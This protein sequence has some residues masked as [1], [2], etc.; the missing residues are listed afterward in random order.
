MSHLLPEQRTDKNGVTS[1]KWVRPVTSHPLTHS[2][3]P[4]PA[5]AVKRGNPAVQAERAYLELKGL[6]HDLA[7]K[8]YTGQNLRFL[9][10]YEPELLNCIMES[11]RKAD[12]S[13]MAIL[14]QIM[15]KGLPDRPFESDQA[16]DDFLEKNIP[17]YYRIVKNL[18]LATA[19]FPDKGTALQID[20]TKGIAASA[21]SAMG[22]SFKQEDCSR[23]QAAMIIFG[24][25]T[26]KSISDISEDDIAFVA[27]N[28]DRIIPLVPELMK[29]K[30]STR[31][32]IESLWANDSQ[33]LNEGL[34]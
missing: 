9:A 3:L 32:L 19:L 8:F 27:E 4:A 30:S 6:D 2:S 14:T 24:T 10:E 11:A 20:F 29:R 12:A 22:M 25:T 18:S 16:M 23:G 17:P 13:G 31:D 26:G 1:T 5:P 28:I 33:V 21:E 34:L 7:A 15:E